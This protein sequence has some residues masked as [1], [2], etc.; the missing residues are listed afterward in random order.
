MPGAKNS[1]FLEFCGDVVPFPVAITDNAGFGQHAK[2]RAGR[3]NTGRIAGEEI[4]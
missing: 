2:G 3:R 4:C 1:F